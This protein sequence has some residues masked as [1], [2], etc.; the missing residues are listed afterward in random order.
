NWTF[1][2]SQK[3][4]RGL[5]EI[6]PRRCWLLRDGQEVRV[7]VSELKAGDVVVVK[8]GA[9][10]PADG[11]IRDGRSTLDVSA[12]TGESL[13]VEKGPADGDG[14]AHQGRLGPGAARG[15]QRLR[16]R[17]DRHPHRGPA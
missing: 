7:L 8:P 9:R 17:Q 6:T 14:R 16:I 13:P 3:A 1:T 5:L 2:R 12:L 4:I 15:G 11:I 10:I